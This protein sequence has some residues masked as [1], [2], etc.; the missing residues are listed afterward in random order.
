MGWPRRGPP[1]E[2]SRVMERFRQ[3]GSEPVQ[4]KKFDN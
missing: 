2:C 1:S 3:A 4:G